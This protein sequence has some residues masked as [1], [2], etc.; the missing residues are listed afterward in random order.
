MN[1]LQLVT[2]PFLPPILGEA[3]FLR[4]LSR[5]VHKDH[6][7]IAHPEPIDHALDI[8]FSWSFLIPS[9]QE[10][11][12]S[13]NKLTNTIVHMGMR[14]LT[15]EFGLWSN[16]RTPTIADVGVWSTIKTLTLDKLIPHSLQEWYKFCEI[17]FTSGLFTK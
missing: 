17:N 5:R 2:S 10:N 3:N 9:P 15:N 7:N 14:E 4:Y 11:N 6:Q 16:K 13:S 8:C 1:V 12:V